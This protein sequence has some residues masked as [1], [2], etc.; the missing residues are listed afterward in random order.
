MWVAIGGRGSERH[1]SRAY[2]ERRGEDLRQAYVA[3][4]PG[5]APGRR[6]VGHLVRDE[7]L[8]SRP[9]GSRAG[10]GP[11]RCSPRR[12]RCRPTTTWSRRGWA[13]WPGGHRAGSVS[14]GWSDPRGTAWG[15]GPA[16]E[17][18]LE[19]CRFDRVL[20]DSWRRTSSIP[21]S[22]A[23][24]HRAASG[25]VVGSEAEPPGLD[26]EPEPGPRPAPLDPEAEGLTADALL[27]DPAAGD[28]IRHSASPVVRVAL[29]PGVRHGRPLR[30]RGCRLLL[31][32]SGGVLAQA[33]AESGG[34]GA[35]P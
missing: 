14:S 7:E 28:E 16:V 23:D 9:P 1:K 2:D 8:V 4:D 12:P 26:D 18:A 30:A 5:P 20:D 6:L 24:S 29:G 11:A 33:V 25:S 32:R 31:P 17:P 27:P 15:E 3:R 19:V 13:R 10:T 34:M 21:R 22:P 35:G